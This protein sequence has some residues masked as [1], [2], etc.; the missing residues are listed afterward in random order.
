MGT[1]H[2][3]LILVGFFAG[4]LSGSVGFGGGMILLP[5]I[6]SIYGIEVAVPV[7]TIAQVLSNLSRVVLGFKSIQWRQ[8][9]LFLVFAAPL[10]A[11]GA[12]GFGVVPKQLMTRLL[13]LFLIA[14]AVMKLAGKLNLRRSKVTMLAGGGIT[15]F[16]NGLLGISGPLSGAVFFSLGLAPVAYIASE[17]TAATVMHLIKIVV[18]R[19]LDLV[20]WSVFLNGLYIGIAM[21]AGNLLAFKTVL[22]INKKTY[23]K[24][25]ASVMILVSIWLFFSV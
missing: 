19:Q 10:T 16:I 22:N 23:Q 7:S 11:L 18:Y 6:T 4:F 20:D 24:I 5:V 15:G 8:V 14:F 17:A 2:I 9:G 21:I 25:V 3:L 12:Y 13:C 1:E